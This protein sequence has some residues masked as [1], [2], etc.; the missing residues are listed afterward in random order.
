METIRPDEHGNS[1]SII[2]N[3]HMQIC[4]FEGETVSILKA[5]TPRDNFNY[6]VFSLTICFVAFPKMGKTTSI[7]L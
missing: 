5:F 4:L 3:N 1:S 2:P 7:P 6:N